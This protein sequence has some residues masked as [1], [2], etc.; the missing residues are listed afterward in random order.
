M[1]FLNEKF[2]II[3]III[4]IIILWGFFTS[5][6]PMVS[7]WFEGLQLSSNL[8]ESSQYSDRSQ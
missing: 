5:A 4:I 2:I 7:H 1:H 3:I 6:Y 8:Q